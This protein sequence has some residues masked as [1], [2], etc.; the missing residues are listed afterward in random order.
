MFVRRYSDAATEYRASTDSAGLFDISLRGKLLVSGEDATAFLH[1]VISADIAGL[2]PGR[3]AYAALLEPKGKYLADLKAFRTGKGILL[4]CPPFTAAALAERLAAVR[5]RSRVE[6]RDLTDS[7]A[8]FSLQGAAAPRAAASAGLGALPAGMSA[9]EDPGLGAWLAAQ[10]DETPAGG[11]WLWSEQEAAE[12]LWDALVRSGAV[13]CGLETLGLLR[14][15]AGV[16]AWG[17]DIDETV[18]PLEAGQG[19]ALCYDKC[20]PGQEVVAR[21]HFRGHVNRE[22]RMLEFSGGEPLVGAAIRSEGR[23]AGAVTSVARNPITGAVRG[24]GYVR[25]SALSAGFALVAE[26]S[27]GSCEVVASSLPY[28]PDG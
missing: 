3:W 28:P 8:L 13:P 22:L 6:I 17:R 15:E 27:G 21:I 10:V 24:L 25:R 23:D 4:D 2:Y 26:W 18:I 5:F 1:G 14:I 16:P 12:S 20:Y 7:T 9:L 11:L 19:R